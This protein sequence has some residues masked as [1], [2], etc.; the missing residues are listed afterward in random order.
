MTAVLRGSQ[1]RIQFG[2]GEFESD[3][4]LR[5]S[6]GISVAGEEWPSIELRL[7]EAS[8]FV[9]V[10][11]IE[12]AALAASSYDWPTLDEWA[13]R[14]DSGA[15]MRVVAK[16]SG[17][18]RNVTLN[19]MARWSEEYWEKEVEMKVTA[20]ALEVFWTPLSQAI[21]WPQRSRWAT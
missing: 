7:D 14:Q 19:V 11:M 17:N 18:N 21:R 15:R 2:D 3:D 20:S 5:C 4:S 9:L 12:D 13:D 8:R 16:T 6:V 1:A 10:A